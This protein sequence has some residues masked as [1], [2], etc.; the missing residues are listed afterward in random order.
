MSTS[1]DFIAGVVRGGAPGKTVVVVRKKDGARYATDKTVFTHTAD[2]GPRPSWRLEPRWS[3]RTHFKS[4]EAIKREFT[5]LDG[6][7]ITE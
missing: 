5:N 6:S 7:P 3:G 4:I 1:G 2:T